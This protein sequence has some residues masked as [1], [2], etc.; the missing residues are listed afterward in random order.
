MHSILRQV[1]RLVESFP[2]ITLV[3]DETGAVLAANQIAV[4]ELKLIP[5]PD[6]PATF[7]SPEYTHLTP[8]GEPAPLSHTPFG[9][10]RLTKRPVYKQPVTL[11]W[12]DGR[13][14]I[15]LVNVMPLLD[16]TDKFV[17]AVTIGIEATEQLEAQLG[18]QQAIGELTLLQEQYRKLYRQTPAI[19][20]SIDGQ[21]R[22][23]EVSD[24][25]LTT[26]GYTR[27]EVIGR[28]S[29]AFLTEASQ[30]Y[31]REV[32][33]PAYFRD[34]Y[35]LAV[36]YQFLTKTGEVRDIELSAIAEKGEDGTFIRSLAVLEDVT[37][38]KA[39]EKHVRTLAQ[40]LSEIQEWERSQLAAE[41]HDTI[42]RGLG[43][44]S[45]NLS[46][47]IQRLAPS[48]PE[49]ETLIETLAT[50]ASLGRQMRGIMDD[51]RPRILDRYGFRTTL[52]WLAD[53]AA[54]IPAVEVRAELAD[55]EP[56]LTPTCQIACVRIAQEAIANIRLHAQASS[57]L[58]TSTNGHEAFRLR[59]QDDGVGFDQSGSAKGPGWGTTIMRERAEAVEGH[60]EIRSQ[61]GAGTTVIITMP[62]TQ[63]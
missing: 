31:A 20:H 11:S 61:P 10:A 47:V 49:R 44:V 13:R 14:T 29:T 9:L 33:L 57:V 60:V 16:E 15:Y 63:A 45:F 8:D 19:L 43:G 62:T 54:A 32:V 41:L 23:L 17:G 2:A 53:R 42:G 6:D 3:R 26:F 21:G 36:S 7:A 1:A 34:G 35:C 37:E 58:I 30:Q 4:A 27:A 39:A 55:G 52:S 25:W 40:R 51:L 24:R 50:V 18:L 48:S 56:P 38:R 12:A 59:I 28:P 22:L 46:Q 5:A